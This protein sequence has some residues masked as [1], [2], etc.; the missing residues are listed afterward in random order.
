M[1]DYTVNRPG[2]QSPLSAT[3]MDPAYGRLPSHLSAPS[4]GYPADYVATL[5]GALGQLD[6]NAMVRDGIP[7]C[8]KLTKPEVLPPAHPG[9]R[10][11]DSYTR[12]KHGWSL[13]RLWK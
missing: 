7:H 2:D 3:R 9:W 13:S 5:T 1:T 11:T 4:L 12:R 6:I 8:D 10:L